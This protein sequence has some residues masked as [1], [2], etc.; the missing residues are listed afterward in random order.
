MATLRFTVSCG[1]QR[2]RRAASLRGAK[3]SMGRLMNNVS[4]GTRGEIREDGLLVLVG[5]CYS[6]GWFVVDEV[7]ALQVA[8]GLV[9]VGR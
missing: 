7:F 4:K 2:P 1:G 5:E 8:S 3:V 6:L 9:A